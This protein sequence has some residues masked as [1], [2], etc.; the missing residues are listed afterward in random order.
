MDINGVML[1]LSLTFL[2]LIQLIQAQHTTGLHGLPYAFSPRDKAV[3]VGILGGRIQRAKV[4]LIENLMLFAPLSVL[5]EALH[6][7]HALVGWGA[8][9][10]FVARVLHF[11]MYVAGIR[12]IRT[13]AWLAGVVGCGMIAFALLGWA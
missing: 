4:N 8:V 10:F 13:L 11:L 12:V 3:D 6:V 2:L 1:I 5:A 7:N 9:L